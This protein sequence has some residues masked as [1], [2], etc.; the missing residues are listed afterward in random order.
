MADH[1]FS[2]LHNNMDTENCYGVAYLA[3]KYSCSTMQKI[4][5]DFAV[6]NFTKL[7]NSDDFHN[8]NLQYLIELISNNALNVTSECEVR[9]IY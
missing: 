1:C 4:V 9:E 3:E 2:Y 5:K 7:V 6:V 8:I